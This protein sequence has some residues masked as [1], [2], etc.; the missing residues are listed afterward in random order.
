L[1]IKVVPVTSEEFPRPAKRPKWS[2]LENRALKVVGKN[3][4]RPWKDALKEYLLN[5]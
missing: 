2:V 3:V 1:G 5:D 4:F